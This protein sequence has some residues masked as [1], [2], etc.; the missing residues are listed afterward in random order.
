MSNKSNTVGQAGAKNIMVLFKDKQYDDIFPED[1]KKDL[2]IVREII[3]WTKKIQKQMTI[4]GK[5]VDAKNY[6]ITNRE[7]LVIKHANAYSS[8]AVF[9]GDDCDMEKWDGI[10][11]WIVQEIV[12]L[13]ERE[14]EYW[15]DDQ[16]KKKKCIFNVNPYMYDGKLGGFYVRAST[17]RLTSFKV[18][19]I[20]TVMPCFKKK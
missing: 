1:L 3:P 12:D 16:V 11:D 13:P 18:G 6:L 19:E 20:A 8:M 15:E 10:G 7:K 9:I 5:E 4:D 17:D 2:E 14:I